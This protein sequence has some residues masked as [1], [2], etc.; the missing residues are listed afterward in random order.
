[1][2]EK[3]TNKSL[4]KQEE[5]ASKKLI[6]ESTKKCPNCKR[7]IEKSFGCDHMTCELFAFLANQFAAHPY[8]LKVGFTCLASRFCSY[9][10]R[11]E[12]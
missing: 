8:L 9:L 6:L 11:F 4:K 3:R 1:M 2:I 5:A 12:M 7:S 10:R